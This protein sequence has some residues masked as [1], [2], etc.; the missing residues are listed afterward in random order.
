MARFCPECGQDLRGLGLRAA[1]NDLNTNRPDYGEPYPPS[2]PA[3]PAG[4]EVPVHGRAER[5]QLSVVFCDLVGSSELAARI[6]PEDLAELIGRFHRCVSDTMGRYGGFYTPPM[7]DGALV[8]FGFPRAHEDDV[9]RAVRAGLRTLEAVSAIRAA[10][11]RH[12]HAR[13]GIATGIA[14]V[15]DVADTGTAHRLYAAGEALNLAARLQQLAEPDT[16]VVADNVRRLAG[17]LFVY[18]DLGEHTFKGWE[19]PI[20]VAQ[21]LRPAVNP[22]RFEARLGSHPTPLIG[23]CGAIETLMTLWRAVRGGT[24]RVALVTGEPGIGKSRL[25][26]ELMSETAPASHTRIRWFCTEHQQGVALHPCL[27]QLEFAAGIGSEDPP[28]LRRSKLEAVLR[29]AS[30]EDFIL[31][32]SLMRVPVDPRSTVLQ[33]SLQRRRERTLR[34]FLSVLIRLCQQRPVLAILEDAHW[35]DPTTAELL[36]LVAREAES[37][38]LLL[39]VTARPDFKPHWLNARWVSTIQLEPLRPEQSAELVRSVAESDG[40]TETVVQAITARCDGVPLF[41]EEVTRAVLEADGWTGPRGGTVPASIHASLLARLDRLGTARSVME[42]AAVI[43]RDFSVELLRQVDDGGNHALDTSI[44]RLVDAGLVV[45]SGSSESGQYH[46]KHALIRDTAYGMMLRG[47]R[48]VLHSRVAETLEIHFPQTAT[49]EPQTLAHHYTEAGLAETAVGWWRRAGTQSLLR[50]AMP[51]AM[52]QL[53]RGLELCEDLPD[54][55]AR[56][57][58]ELDLQLGRG[59]AIIATQGHATPGFDAYLARAR[60]L[61][62]KLKEPPQLLTVMFQAWTQALLCGE[63]P[64]ARERAEELLALARERSDGVWD[65]LACYAAGYTYFVLGSFH[66]AHHH[67]R[68]GLLLFEPDRHEEYTSRVVGDPRVMLRT[69]LAWELMCTGNVA[70][71]WAASTAAVGNARVLRNS[72][73]LAS[74]LGNQASLHT[75]IGTPTAGLAVAEELQRLSD[76]HG[77]AFYEAIATILRG[78]FHSQRGDQDRGLT[79]LQQGRARYNTTGT[80]L[81]LPMAIRFEAEL[82]GRSGRIAEA[83]TRITEA[84]TVVEE[85][86]QLW[87]EAETRRVE[88]ELLGLAGNRAAAE[89]ALREADRVAVTQGARLFALRARI[90]L[91]TLRPCRE[92]RAAMTEAVAWFD[93]ACEISDVLR[94]RELLEERT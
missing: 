22:S 79:L 69:Y 9:E 7:G 45:P 62:A 71:A 88:G 68:R 1:R 28:A 60:E 92:I 66:T 3:P 39:V 40:L 89:A 93:P 85:T 34:A 78:W 84:R 76:E 33:F 52:A 70:E 5:R 53:S 80:R 72:Y 54:T 91:A 55:E 43:G 47:R 57:R 6:D 67:L 56:R 37:V 32:A 12:L 77:I 61:C 50:A 87:E 16:L 25:A 4:T 17:K 65:L 23:R 51:E 59:K 46:F 10:G 8:F 31:I 49:A 30:E 73:S 18:R 35:S 27:Q 36:G 64:S 94:A 41:L 63:L 2:A 15:G 75:F 38:P 86:S 24:G 26:A 83:L 13:I 11:G 48:R 21:V 74:A 44:R 19:N 58:L 29:G 90:S 14:I 82:L 42:A 20:A 81:H